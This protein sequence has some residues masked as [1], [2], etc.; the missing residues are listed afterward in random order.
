MRSDCP[1]EMARDAAHHLWEAARGVA[2]KTSESASVG[3]V[4]DLFMAAMR[5]YYATGGEAGSCAVAARYFKDVH[6][7]RPIGKLVH[8]DMLAVR[9]A[10]VRFGRLARTTINRYIQ[11]LTRRMMPRALDAGLIRATTKVELSQ[12]TPLK[13]GRC[14]AREC[15]PV[16]KADNA[17]VEAAAMAMVAALPR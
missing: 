5:G 14:A 10:T 8:T 1:V 7:K 13:R 3:E 17:D 16:R 6:G 12:V 15:R 11:I 9:E 4:C 2:R